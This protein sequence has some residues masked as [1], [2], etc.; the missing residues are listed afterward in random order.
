M[1]GLMQHEELL[2]SSIIRHAARHHGRGEVVSRLADGSLHRCTYAVVEERARRLMTVLGGLGVGSGDRVATFAWNS[3]RHLEAY[4]A[5]SGMGAVCHTVNPRL[6]EADLAFI[7]DHARDRVVL[8]DPMFLPLLARV[9]PLTTA[10]S[11]R[12]V[13]ALGEASDVAGTNLGGVEIL[14]YETLLDQ[15]TPAD[16][17]RLDERMASGLCYTSGTTGRPKGVLYSHRS[18]VLNAMA[19]NGA[20][21][22]G[23]RAVDRV[24]PAVPMFHVNAWGLPYLA[25]MV[26]AALVMPGRHLDGASLAGLMQDERVT[27]SAGVPTVWLGLLAHLDRGTPTPSALRRMAI[28]GS[29]CPRAIVEAFDARGVQVIHAW[30]MTE[31]SP[32]VACNA[33]TPETQTL[34]PEASMRSRLRVG[35][36]AF[37]VDMKAAMEDGREAPW[38]GTTPGNLAC[39]GH[40]VADRYFGETDTRCVDGWL[41]TGD[42]GTIDERGFVDLTDRTKDLIKSGGEWISSIQL[43]RTAA[44]DRGGP[45]RP[46]HRPRCGAA[47]L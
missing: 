17:P 33:D 21:L 8:A 29:A 3:A 5:I 26:G 23:L 4:Y 34:D 44:A 6:A 30:G 32:I 14:A 31:T 28:G 22:L 46:H 9:L 24:L 47:G 2:V 41:P 13:V 18:T 45:P 25:P 35:R 12:C 1:N 36:V 19:I 7:L 27:F 43:G 11:V 20:D 10:G 40:W 37:G 15:A 42:V 38:D 39:R 16:W